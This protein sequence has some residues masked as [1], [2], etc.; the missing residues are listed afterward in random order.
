MSLKTYLNKK[1]VERIEKKAY[2]KIVAKRKTQA[3]REA[4]ADE[5]V[6]VA[7]ERARAKARAPSGWAVAGKM[8]AS[9]ARMISKKV[10]TPKRRASPVK[11]KKARS[12]MTINDAIY[13]GF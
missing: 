9:G 12:P 1:K 5:A 10:A 11:R 3:A 13:G 6:K 7:R 8:V 4:Y 2:R